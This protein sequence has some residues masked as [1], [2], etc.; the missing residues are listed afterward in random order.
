MSP[1]IQKK[2]RSANSGKNGTIIRTEK[3]VQVFIP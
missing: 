1:K 3:I 2:E